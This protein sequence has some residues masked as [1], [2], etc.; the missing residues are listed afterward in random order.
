MRNRRS[1]EARKRR[2]VSNK[3]QKS[4]RSTKEYDDHKRPLKIL[5]HDLTRGNARFQR[6]EC[7]VEA[8]LGTGHEDVICHDVLCAKEVGGVPDIVGQKTLVTEVED[9]LF[10]FF[11]RINFSVIREYAHEIFECTHECVKRTK[12]ELRK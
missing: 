4:Q 11:G 12:L 2:I 1:A 10:S 9:E 7:V 6:V 3:A 5:S 8:H